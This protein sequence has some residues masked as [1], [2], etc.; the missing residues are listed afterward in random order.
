M[1]SFYNLLRQPDRHVEAFQKIYQKM[2]D[3]VPWATRLVRREG[4]ERGFSG[5]RILIPQGV[6]TSIMRLQASYMEHPAS[7]R[8]SLQAIAVPVENKKEAKILTAYINSRLAIWFALHGTSSFGVD[9]PKVHQ[10][11]LLWLPFPESKETHDPERSKKAA[12]DIVQLVDKFAEESQNLFSNDPGNENLLAKIDKL[13]YEYFCLSDDEITIIEDTVELI[14]PAVQPNKGSYTEVC[15]P[16]LPQERQQYSAV[17]T[18]SLQDWFDK[19]S[20]INVRLEAINSDLAILKLSLVTLDKK[21]TYQ[22]NL[23]HRTANIHSAIEK[24]SQ[25]IQRPI[26][27]NFQLMPDFRVFIG[28]DLYLVKPLQKRFWLRSAALADADAIAIDIQDSI[29]LQSH[30]GGVQ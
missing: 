28:S 20:S 23:E 17:L 9:R 4:F 6:E 8:D 13:I 3:S 24:L 7:F 2:V 18:T 15:K 27:G 22:E 11:E 19:E 30:N 26:G 12:W 29:D 14:L 10:E 5:P 16:S 1:L 25:H 21:Q